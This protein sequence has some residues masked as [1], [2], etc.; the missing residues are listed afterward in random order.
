MTA[1]DYKIPVAYVYCNLYANFIMGL[2]F[3]S[4]S[5]GI[6]YVNVV[7][8]TQGHK[9]IGYVTIDRKVF[10]LAM[11]FQHRSRIERAVNMS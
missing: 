6:V 5:V 3:E 4:V 7:K 10:L 9:C 11:T 2:S 1:P 8:Q